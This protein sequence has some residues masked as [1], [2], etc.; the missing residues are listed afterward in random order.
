MATPLDREAQLDDLLA[1]YLVAEEEGRAP[2]R[3]EW[4]KGH[5]QYAVELKAFFADRGQ[6]E[7][8]AQPLKAVARAARLDA[9]ADDTP[10]NS[11]TVDHVSKVPG[12]TP[13]NS[14]TIDHVS[15][16]PGKPSAKAIP[17]A[18]PTVAGYKILGVLGRGGMGV[19]YKARELKLNRVV[20]LKMILQGAHADAEHLARFRAEAEA[21]A[22][23]HH[24]NIVQIFEINEIDG[25]PYLALEFCPGGS[26]SAKL[27][28]AGKMLAPAKPPSCWK[29]WP[30]P[31]NTPTASRW[32][33]AISSR[34]IYCSAPTAHRR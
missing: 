3:K 19:V 20:A 1:S 9:A 11:L 2:D 22:R 27:K 18:A 4:L 10:R 26:L 8:M 21:V 16:G 25:L 34:G 17:A 31:W 13:K 30:W 23:L 29:R 24:P 15:K 28:A 14:A 7:G 5:P 33:T 32:C 6:V 12:D